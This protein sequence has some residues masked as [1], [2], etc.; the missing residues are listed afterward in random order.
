MKEKLTLQQKLWV[1]G[2]VFGQAFKALAL[3][4][5]MPAAC[6]AFGY[7]LWHKDMTAQEFFTYGG[8]FYT[9]AGMCLTIWMLYRSSKKRGH[10]FFEDATLYLDRVNLKKSVGFFAF[11]I[12]SAVT[13]SAVLTLLPRWEVMNDYSQ[14][15]QTMFKGRDVLFT[16]I[17]TV[18]TAPLAEEIVFRGYIL[19]TLIEPLGERKAVL[20]V[21]LVFA[22]CH[23]EAIWFFY[24]F[25]MGLVLAWASLREDNIFYGILLHMGFNLPSA[26]TWLVSSIPALSSVFFAG[27]GLAACYGLIGGL[28]VL[29]LARAYRAGNWEERG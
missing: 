27:K 5:M 25:A 23:G 1:R 13:I 12:A 3:Y 26:V 8:N 24:A 10:G 16:V 2:M 15:S 21:S 17:T 29:L 28:S 6:M 4:V 19:N 14:A 22:L 20:L 7:V 9:A 11:G 18:F